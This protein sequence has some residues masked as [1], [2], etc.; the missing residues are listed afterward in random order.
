MKLVNYNNYQFN[1]EDELLLLRPFRLLFNADRTVNKDKFM[2]FLSIV[3]FTYDP[4]SD[5]TYIV[6]DELR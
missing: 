3:Y 6:D 5:Y 1:I 2:N 4:R